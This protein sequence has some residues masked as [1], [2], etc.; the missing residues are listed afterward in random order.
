MSRILIHGTVSMIRSGNYWTFRTIIVC[1]L[2]NNGKPIGKIL[3]TPLKNNE[4]VS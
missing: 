1:R 4:T 3:V 2:E